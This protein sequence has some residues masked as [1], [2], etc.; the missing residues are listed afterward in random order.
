MEPHFAEYIATAGQMNT[1]DL[2]ILEWGIN[3]LGWEEEKIYD[4]VTG[5]IEK[6][7]SANPEKTIFVISPF[8]H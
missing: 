1:W 8:Y 6:K 4:C 5:I 3:V 2:L 7:A